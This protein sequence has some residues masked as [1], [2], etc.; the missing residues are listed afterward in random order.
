MKCPQCKVIN[1][2]KRKVK[3]KDFT[4]DYCPE[5]KGFWFDKN[6]FEQITSTAIKDLVVPSD[7]LMGTRECPRCEKPLYQFY[8]PQTFVIID[9]CNKCKGFWLDNGE[10]KEINAI[11]KHMEETGELTEY[12]DPTGIKG[13]LIRFVDSAIEKLK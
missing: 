11:R 12:T 3:E 7:S 2:I 13:A 1:L 8:Y 5:C 9:M 4:V 10:F 6:E